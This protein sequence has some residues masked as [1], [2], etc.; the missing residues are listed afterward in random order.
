MLT[1]M[2][3]ANKE[4]VWDEYGVA[5]TFCKPINQQEF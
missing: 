5:K 4:S 2:E 1:S 3:E